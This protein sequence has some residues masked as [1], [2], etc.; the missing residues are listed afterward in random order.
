MHC[1]LHCC[2][3]R[4]AIEQLHPVSLS[5]LAAASVL[6]SPLLVLS[7]ASSAAHR[8]ALNAH[9]VLA[10]HACAPSAQQSRLAKQAEQE[11]FAAAAENTVLQGRIAELRH[12]LETLQLKHDVD[13]RRRDAEAA[14]A[15]AR[16][17]AACG[18]RDELEARLWPPFALR[19]VVGC[20][21]RLRR[22]RALAGAAVGMSCVC[23]CHA[24]ALASVR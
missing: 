7:H 22:F 4:N 1:M 6:A 13:A 2:T 14:A 18:E 15:A 5:P 11:R 16:L 20:T 12:Q 17:E 8:T 24:H 19:A 9:T 23:L 3:L 21:L 10:P